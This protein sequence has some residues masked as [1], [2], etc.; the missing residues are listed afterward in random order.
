MNTASLQAYI[1]GALKIDSLPLSCCLCSLSKT[2]KATDLGLLPSLSL[3]W[4]I[5]LL[6]MCPRCPRV[7]CAFGMC[8]CF[9]SF[10][11]I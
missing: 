8:V 5:L 6:R 2:K 4:A 1:S 10:V 7:L 3:I 9:F 11:V